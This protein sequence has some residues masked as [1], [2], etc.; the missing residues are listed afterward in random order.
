MMKTNS[1]EEYERIFLIFCK[2]KIIKNPLKKK[3]GETVEDGTK[4]KLITLLQ[5]H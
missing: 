5:T 2:K 3:E 1:K 4:F